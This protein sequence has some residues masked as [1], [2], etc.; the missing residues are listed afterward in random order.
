MRVSADF[1]YELDRL[2][3]SNYKNKILLLALLVVFIIFSVTKGSSAYNSDYI[4]RISIDDQ[5][6][7]DVFAINS[8]NEIAKDEK[9]S[10]LI[11]HINSPGGSPYMSEEIF[12][13][14]RRISDAAKPVV[15]V[16]GSMAASGGYMVA[17][18]GDQIFAG[19]TSITGSIGAIMQTIDA[20]VL[21]DK[22]GVKI[23]NYSYPAMK[24]E[25]NI[26]EKTP[27]L[28]QAILNDVAVDVY[29]SFLNMVV[30]R[31]NL[32][33]EDLLQFADGRVYTGRQALKLKLIDRIGG[34]FE[35]LEWLYDEKHLSKDSTIRDYSFENQGYG[36]NRFIM[37]ASRMV[38]NALSQNVTNDLTNLLKLN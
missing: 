21:A 8:L 14:L 36:V 11:V 4:A 2:R 15:V 6:R 19:E 12:R 34:E 7:D 17:L 32:L 5:I 13:S 20:S 38:L 28:A 27:P 25:P 30:V 16:I 29:E 9:I 33:K 10:A 1:L 31:R 24:G 35:A 22:L 23:K 37:G 3:Q 26:T 18:A